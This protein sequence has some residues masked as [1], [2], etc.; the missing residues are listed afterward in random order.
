MVVAEGAHPVPVDLLTPAEARDLL[1]RRIGTDR[2]SAAPRVVDEII[3]RCARLPLALAIVAARAAAHPDFSLAVLADELPSADGHG[4]DAFAGDDAAT[5]V[6]AVFS[7]SCQGLSYAA[8]HL[9][10]LLGLHPGPDLDA[11]AVASLASVSIA[12]ARLLLAE[13]AR[14]NLVTEHAPGRFT[15]HDL[16]REFATEHARSLDPEPVLQAAMHRMLDHYLHTA[17]TAASRLNPRRDAITL[18]PAQPGVTPEDLLNPGAAMAWFTAEYPVLLAIIERA[19]ATG[20]ST[21]ARQL[22]LTLTEFRRDPPALVS[23]RSAR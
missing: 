12:Q 14:A 9:F 13:L 16:L 22:P 3:S 21:H 11:A 1:A 17:H 20:F 2:V 15:I 5:D 6:R 7:W 4:L 18:H 23:R 19:A 8:C 10:R